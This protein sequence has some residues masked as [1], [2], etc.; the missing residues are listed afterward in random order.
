MAQR[1]PADGEGRLPTTPAG[2][3]HAR[4]GGP[5]TQPVG[6]IL[7]LSLCRE[8]DRTPTP[9]GALA[10]RRRVAVGS[11]TASEAAVKGPL[12]CLDLPRRGRTHCQ[13]GLDQARVPKRVPNLFTRARDLRDRGIE[14]EIGR[15][16]TGA[17]LELRAERIRRR[18]TIRD[19]AEASGLG[20]STVHAVEAGRPAAIE[21]YVRLARALRLR[22]E[23]AVVDPRR[24]A[25]ASARAED[26]VHAAM[27]EIEAAHFRGLGFDVGMDEP[28]QHFQFAGRGDLVAWSP[29]EAAMLHVEN[30]TLF[31]NLQ[32]A[33]GSFNAKRAYLGAELAS[34]AGVGLWRSETHVLV[35]L[36]SAEVLHQM[37][38]RRASFAGVCPDGTGAF[39]SWWR[40]D[41]PTGGRST[42]LLLFDPIEGTRSDRHRWVGIDELAEIRPRYSG[43]AEAL[44]ALRRAGLV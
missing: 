24:H 12:G 28:F 40:G 3:G 11:K 7:Q 37:R 36:W 26:P 44:A 32:E 33:F 16:A 31:P 4:C 34:R 15:L 8:Q 42:T 30:R 6:S 19:L 13:S 43:Y 10:P 27:G 9:G 35:A 21:T 41:L 17:G 20:A 39:G 25:P 38:V 2:S 29:Q 23:L 1:I 22:P 14:A 5:D 18:M